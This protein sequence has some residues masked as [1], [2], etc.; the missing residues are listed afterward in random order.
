MFRV[1]I[2]CSQY[3]GPL[4]KV[5]L[6]VRSIKRGCTVTV[7]VRRLGSNNCELESSTRRG[8]SSDCVRLSTYHGLLS[9]PVL[10]AQ[11]VGMDLLTMQSITMGNSIHSCGTL[12]HL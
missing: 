8:Q 7:M 4:M 10:D 9:R 1:V 3:E 12:V 2:K 5:V 11:A 6:M